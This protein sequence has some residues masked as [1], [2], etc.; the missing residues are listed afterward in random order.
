[1][2]VTVVKTLKPIYEQ[3]TTTADV[4]KTSEAKQVMYKPCEH[5][6]RTS[7]KNGV[8]TYEYKVK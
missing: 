4:H 6:E 1:M 5:A 7:K 8:L 3:E 2:V